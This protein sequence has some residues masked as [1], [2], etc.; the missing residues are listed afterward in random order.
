MGSTVSTG[1]MAA[2]FTPASGIPCY[3]LFEETY[4]K[5]CYPHTQ[6]WSCVAMGSLE[7]VVRIV[8]LSGS[9]CEGGSLQGANGRYITPEGYIAG[10]LSELANPVAFTDRTITLDA[11]SR[12]NPSIPSEQLG[13]A[14]AKLIALGR[15]D[16]AKELG[17]GNT[18]SLSLHSDCQVLVALYD[19]TTMAPWRIIQS[20]DV[21][22]TGTRTPALGYAPEKAKLYD[23]TMPRFYKIKELDDNRL[24]Q[25]EDG[26]WS[27]AGWE[28]ACVANYVTNLWE[29]ELCEP[30]T[31]RARIK[32]Y[33]EAIRGAPYI[34]AHGVKVVVDTTIVIEDYEQGSVDRTVAA[35]PSTRDG[36]VLRFE[37][38]T[39]DSML[40]RVTALPAK[41]TKWIITESAPTEQLSLLAS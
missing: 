30:G 11:V 24:I 6:S 39:D 21:P 5:N 18:V 22:L 15:Q 10:W 17:Q 38:P 14:M 7:A 27:C 19:R 31:Y 34:P 35:L 2:A 40:Y 36:N 1:K 26:S 8:F 29:T 28:Y 9:S 25:A 41:C 13:T 4:E 12:Y 23:L 20:H 16:I 33:R 37:V 3:L 32:A